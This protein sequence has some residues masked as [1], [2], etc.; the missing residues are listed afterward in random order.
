MTKTPHKRN[1]YSQH[2]WTPRSAPVATVDDQYV[3]V[4]RVGMHHANLEAG[5]GTL[6]LNG[7][8]QRRLRGTFAELL[9]GLLA[10]TSETESPLQ[11]VYEAFNLYRG[12]GSRTSE[13]KDVPGGVKLTIRESAP[14]AD[15]VLRLEDRIPTFVLLDTKD[16]LHGM[17]LSTAHDDRQA[18]TVGIWGRDPAVL[19]QLSDWS[20]ELTNAVPPPVGR[21]HMMVVEDD[22]L[23]F[24]PLPVIVGCTL[25]E[26]NYNPE[27][28][29][30][31]R[32]VA[33]D[34]QSQNPKGRIAIFN[35][36]PGTGKTYLLR[37]LLQELGSKTKFVYV[38]PS[39]VIKL[40]SP[41][42]L[43]ALMHFKGE[44]NLPITLL[45][46]DADEILAPREGDNMSHVSALLNLGDGL[47][48]Q[49]LDLRMILTTNAAEQRFDK[50]IIRP[51][52][53]SANVSVEA[54]TR[55]RARDLVKLLREQRGEPIGDPDAVASGP[56]TLAEV[57][58]RA[59]D[60]DFI[61]SKERQAMGY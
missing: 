21:I 38:A 61:P 57:Y 42:T 7:N 11:V 6:T 26:E 49:A 29:V 13:M 2:G 43:P 18:L 25:K 28:L 37:S 27:V 58:Q 33:A 22:S 60:V 36:R 41:S 17:V 48:G 20:V 45:I 51:G 53:L 15:Q 24:K 12:S 19:Q 8:L 1:G 32:R 3:E 34:L 14:P 10:K 16:Q 52:R 30:G 55:D 47:L 35:G 23:E 9:Q 50:A 46:E 40:T 59:L 4:M 44:S 5:F 31:Y 56:M 54:L 39:D